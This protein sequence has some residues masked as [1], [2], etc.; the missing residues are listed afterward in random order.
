MPLDGYYN[1]GYKDGYA[2]KEPDYLYDMEESYLQGYEDGKGTKQL[3]NL[4]DSFRPVDPEYA[5][6]GNPPEGFAWANEKRT[7]NPGDY[8]LTK[9]GGVKLSSSVRKNAQTRHI[10]TPLVKCTCSL[11]GGWGRKAGCSLHSK[12]SF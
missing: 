10:L 9:A 6:L 5:L 12:V 4:A 1:E 3:D 7:P 11:G 8:Y 2:S